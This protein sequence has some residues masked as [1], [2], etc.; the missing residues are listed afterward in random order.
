[1]NI[2]NTF[3]QQ[4]IPS[5][6]LEENDETLKKLILSAKKQLGDQL[7]ILAHHYQK[8]E[9]V[10]LADEIGDS[11]QLAQI[12]NKNQSAKYIVFCGV[13][14]MAETADMLT[15]KSQKVILPDLNAGCS[16]ADMANPYQLQR[17]WEALQQKYPDEILPITYINSSAAIKAFVGKNG[18][19]IVTSSNAE[20]IIRWAFTQKKRIFFLPDQ[21]LGRNTAFHMGIPLSDMALWDPVTNQL[22]GDLKRDIQ[23]I[24]WN[25]WCSVHQQ[26]TLEQINALRE[27]DSTIKI[28]VH[29][30]CSHEIVEAADAYGSTNKILQIVQSSPVDTHWAIGTDNNLV[31]RMKKTLPQKIS[32]LNPNSCPCMTM[33]RIKLPNLAWCVNELAQKKENNIICVD[34]ET[35]NASLAALDK[36]FSCH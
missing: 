8:D 23:V 12:A 15:R 20:K 16:M 24:L 26:F 18:G 34:E 28:V 22:K 6:Y 35:T 14:F 30:E 3:K 27:K 2:L 31:S 7:L 13:H 11:L 1:M 21:H 9:V 10:D 29:P 33:N 17:A 19:S 25:G 32:F 5:S 4:Q 36:M